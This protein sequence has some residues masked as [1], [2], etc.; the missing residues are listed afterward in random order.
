MTATAY[1]DGIAIWSPLLPGWDDARRIFRGEMSV[2]QTK[3]SRPRPSLLPPNE[4]RRA[5]DTV[6]VSLEVASKACAHAGRDPASLPCIFASTH[7]DIATTDYMCETLAQTPDLMSPTKFHNSVHNAAAGYWAI[8]T[9]CMAAYTALS[10]GRHSFGS[11]LLEALVQVQCDDTDIL[12]VAYD[13]EAR[14]PLATMAPSTGQLGCALVLSPAQTENTLY[15]L[16]WQAIEEELSQELAAQGEFAALVAGNAM[17]V[18]LPM[19]EALAGSGGRVTY[20]IG[21]RLVL[22]LTL[23]LPPQNS[24]QT[25]A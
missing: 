24:L 8:A 18:C 9:G 12:Y 17:A 14:G 2:P 4:R 3:A 22:E 13:T 11:G 5:P 19:F 1:I 16:H 25:A 23:E 20:P 6:A 21:Q 10:A 15:T 7:G